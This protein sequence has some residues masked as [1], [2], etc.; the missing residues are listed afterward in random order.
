MGNFSLHLQAIKNMLPFFAV[1]GH[2]LQAQ[3]A[4]IYIFKQCPV[5]SKHTQMFI[6]CFRKACCARGDRFW[7]GLSK[8]LVIEQVLMRS[9]KTA[10]G[11]THGKRMAE[12]QRTVWLLSTPA[13]AEVNR[14]MQEV[15]QVTYETIEQHNGTTQARHREISRTHLAL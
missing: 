15:T 10:G 14:A 7:A 12:L 11:M 5:Y 1:S 2:F 6:E 13:C 3:P 8:D 4:Y 9:L